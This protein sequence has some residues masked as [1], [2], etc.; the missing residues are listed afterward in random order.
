MVQRVVIV[1]LVC[2]KPGGMEVPGRLSPVI[3]MDP[4]SNMFYSCL[5]C[6]LLN[7]FS[8]PCSKPD[9]HVVAAH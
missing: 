3:R 8:T 4:V 7:R 5:V 9:S 2:G 6:G 1:R